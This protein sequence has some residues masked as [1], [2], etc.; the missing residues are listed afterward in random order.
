MAT[1]VLYVSAV[2]TALTA[3]L[4]FAYSCSVNPGLGRLN[5][6][7]YLSAMQHINRAILN[8]AFL[9]TFMGTAIL[10]PVSAFMFSGDR[11]SLRFWLLVAAA[12]VYIIGVM[13]VTMG[14]NVPLNEALDKTDL[15]SASAGQLAEYRR[16]F[17]QPWNKLHAIRTFA[18][19]VT[20]MLVI[21]ACM[22][23]QK[24]V[25]DVLK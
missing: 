14:G 5:D 19:I 7:G 1:F 2:T 21:G 9:L 24:A 3:G 8:P 18:V 10:L 17:E 16:A 4:F 6:I 15:V 12:V 20:V 25:G 22:Q 13:G 11:T 23:Q